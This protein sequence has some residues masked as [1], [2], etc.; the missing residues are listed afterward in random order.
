MGPATG[1][2][3]DDGIHA[4][5][6]ISVKGNRSTCEAQ[7]PITHRPKEKATLVT[8]TI[9][10]LANVLL[11]SQIIEP[12]FKQLPA[13]ASSKH[14]RY[15]WRIAAILALGN[16]ARGAPDF[17]STQLQ[18]IPLTIINLPYDFETKVLHV[19]SVGLIRVTEEVIG[20]GALHRRQALSV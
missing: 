17:I 18:P 14:L 5:H 9:G 10:Q 3:Q 2:A 15:R 1:R 6:V 4:I 16:A 13:F 19:T 11:P 8:S 20:K 12:S 7:Y